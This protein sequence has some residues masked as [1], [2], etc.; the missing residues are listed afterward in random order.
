MA[1][2]SFKGENECICFE[3]HQ[4]KLEKIIGSAILKQTVLYDDVVQFLENYIR[5]LMLGM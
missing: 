4:M 3:K 5:R 1:L 2:D